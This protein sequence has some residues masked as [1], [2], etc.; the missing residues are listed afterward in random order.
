MMTLLDFRNRLPR[1]SVKYDFRM[2]SPLLTLDKRNSAEVAS[3]RIF[4]TSAPASVSGGFPAFAPAEVA[5]EVF[6]EVPPYIPPRGAS[7][8]HKGGS[9]PGLKKATLRAGGEEEGHAS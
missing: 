9:A 6:A 1:T 8:P 7:A 4:G 2:S 5:A 3:L